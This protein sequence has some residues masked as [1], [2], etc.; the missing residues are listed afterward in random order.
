MGPRD[1]TQV[2]RLGSKLL[3]VS[4]VALFFFKDLSFLFVILYV[5]NGEKKEAEI[6]KDH[7]SLV[8]LEASNLV[9]LE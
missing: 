5:K 4:F 2:I 9:E 6:Q 3:F 1:G 7:L 8:P